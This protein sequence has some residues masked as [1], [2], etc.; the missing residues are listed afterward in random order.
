MKVKLE[1]EIEVNPINKKPFINY[2][3]EFSE[4]IEYNLRHYIYDYYTNDDLDEIF[5][6]SELNEIIKDTELEI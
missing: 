1:F 3:K 2:L 5:V 6:K 4:D